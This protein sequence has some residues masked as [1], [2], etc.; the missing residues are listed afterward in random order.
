MLCAAAAAPWLARQRP[1]VW[2]TVVA[3]A[4]GMLRLWPLMRLFSVGFVGWFGAETIAHL[5]LTGQAGPAVAA[6]VLNLPSRGD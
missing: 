2:K 4:F 6:A 1:A 3:A 5:E